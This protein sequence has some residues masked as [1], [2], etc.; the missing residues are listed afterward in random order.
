MK[1]R[2]L[3]ALL[4]RFLKKSL[5]ISLVAVAALSSAP[6]RAMDRVWTKPAGQ[7]RMEAGPLVV[8]DDGKQELLAVDIGGEVMHWG[9]DGKDIGAGQ[10]GLVA[11]LPEGRWTS[12]PARIPGDA[13]AKFVFGSVEGLL[14]ALDSTYQEVW[15]YTLPG[16]TTWSRATPLAVDA[17]GVRLVVGDNSGSVTCLKSDGTVAWRKTFP[18][19]CRTFPQLA[20][21]ANSPRVLIP[22]E[23]TLYC[24][25]LD[26][27][28]AWQRDLGGRIISRAELLPLNGKQ[29]ILCGA[30]AGT[31]H[32][33]DET[34]ATVWS[35]EVGDEIDCSIT[36]IPRE[37]EEPL[38]VCA[39]LWGNLY[40][41]DANGKQLWT[42]VFRAKNRARPVVLDV[43]GKAPS[44]I[45]VTS[46]NNRA[47]AIGQDGRRVDEVHLG[48]SVNGFPV[49]VKGSQPNTVDMVLVTGTLL[50]ERYSPGLP[51]APYRR[52]IDE[53][54]SAESSVFSAEGAI[55]VSFAAPEREN[56]FP[57]VLISNPTG[58]CIAVN[59]EE[60]V[61]MGEPRTVAGA[62][63]SRTSLTLPIPGLA[64]D[65]NDIQV[66]VST[67]VRLPR[68]EQMQ[69]VVRH[70]S[71]V[72][73]AQQNAPLSA[74]ATLPYATFDETRLVPSP[75]EIEWGKTQSIDVFPV[76]VGEIDQGACVVASSLDAPLRTRVEIE[77][78]KS[79]GGATFAGTI[80]AYKAVTVGTV[81]GETVAD[82]LPSL[83]DSGV[84]E[85]P[86]KRAAKLWLS[87]DATR[88]EPGD[89]TGTI[90]IRPLGHEAPDVS[91]PIVIRVVDLR[92][93]RPFPLTLCTWDYI[94][95]NW[96]PN[97][98]EAVLDGMA[99][100]GVNVFPRNVNA[101]AAY[102]N[103]ELTFDWTAF[104]EELA[105][106]KGRGQLLFHV[107]DPAIEFKGEVS[108][109]DRHTAKVEYVRA[110]RDHLSEAGIG[111][112][113]FALYPVDEPG[114]DY[115]PRIPVFIEAASLFREA[116][117]KIRIY[118]D[119]VPG[120][121]W[122]D[123]QRIA[124]Y[125]DVWCPNMRL[126]T[127]LA[128]DDPRIVD[129]MKSGKPVWSYECVSQVK[130]LSPLRYNRANAWRAFYF[131]LDGIGH[132]TFSTTQQNMWFANADKN[133]EY[134]L[135]YPGD[136]PVPSVRWEAVRDGLED[137][138]AATMLRELADRRRG[139]STKEDLVAQADEAVRTISGTILESADE[140]FVESRDFLKAGDRRI[141]H[142]WLDAS[143]FQTYRE[144][145]AELSLELSK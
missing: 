143:A 36:V 72:L 49:L 42:H 83:G 28:V 89:Y 101:K 14:V 97:N 129:I 80:A 67:S 51:H 104:D 128:V 27:N 134:A 17:G 15:R 84:L 30:G 29:L 34:G 94:P 118:T 77:P 23:N 76:Y 102:E 48:G 39:G 32:A 124:P 123:Y 107:S 68:G 52:E 75:A 74:W 71:R 37:P 133:D 54:Q 19:A 25:D 41:F 16:E 70:V 122:R 38:V 142:T 121:S 12:T 88:A 1:D 86:A 96:F 136:L 69:T 61:A 43:D 11:T 130:S 9:V 90:T 53:S 114:L 79:S 24:L 137:V 45:V 62:V 135:V 99:Q 120:L 125:V 145:I 95:N 22:V 73:S 116:D 58:T 65:K 113:D 82:A 6:S 109:P 44:E 138:A 100:H 66:Q 103:G 7:F 57:S 140:A 47:Y 78:P 4:T 64:A 20:T 127:G 10:D 59:V 144:R 35:A 46:Y 91:L 105:R 55:E 115:G 21:I 85:I 110:F 81:N 40:A 33:L 131:G 60:A 50:A 119:P 93:K 26:G 5:S 8:E 106:M 13:R 139:S 2:R 132:W 141:W 18:G 92:M 112:D 87:I 111:Y 98:A 126:V 56:E 31:L 63:S 108:E 3:G 117:P